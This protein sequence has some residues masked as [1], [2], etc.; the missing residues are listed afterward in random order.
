VHLSRIC[1]L[2]LASVKAE[3]LRNRWRE[4]EALS[5]WFDAR[6]QLIAAF[7]YE[8][9]TLVCQIRDG[10]LQRAG[11]LKIPFADW[12]GGEVGCWINSRAVVPPYNKQA[13]MWIYASA[14]TPKTED[15]RRRDTTCD[16]STEEGRVG[17]E[18]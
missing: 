7:W 8:R 18:W 15:L 12:K 4:D 6:N 10:N 17:S 9:H 11:P 13:V 14:T 2:V 1:S 5:R 16:C 3:R